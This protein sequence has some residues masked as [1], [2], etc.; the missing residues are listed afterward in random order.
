[1]LLSIHADSDKY[2]FLSSV[3][4]PTNHFPKDKLFKIK[5]IHINIAYTIYY[6]TSFTIYLLLF[7]LPVIFK[8]VLNVTKHVARP[9]YDFD[10]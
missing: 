9:H 1:M 4:F 6:S 5:L 10:I 2:I 7:T 3:N 8:N